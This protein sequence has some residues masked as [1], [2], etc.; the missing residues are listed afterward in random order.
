M[1]A[2][3]TRGSTFVG[4]ISTSR[5]DKDFRLAFD[6]HYRDILAYAKRRSSPADAEDIAA[7]TFTI[8]WRKWN[9][10]PPEAIRPW[11]FGIARKVL[12]N[13]R[14]GSRRQDRL[15]AKV[16]SL[17]EQSTIDQPYGEHQDVNQAMAGLRLADSEIIR[18]HCWEDLSISEIAIVLD[19]SPNAASIRL[20]RAK[21]RLHQALISGGRS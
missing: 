10:A 15:A 21:Q 8:A 7:E 13:S 12:A 5:T 4:S 3:I 18:L 19:C 2:V 9:S 14:R 17:T 20:H 16:T 1:N 6:Q 11:L